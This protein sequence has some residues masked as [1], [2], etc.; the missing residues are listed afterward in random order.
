M[1]EQGISIIV[2][3]D[4]HGKV[5]N[6]RRFSVPVTSSE[7]DS[8]ALAMSQKGATDIADTLRAGIDEEISERQSVNNDLQG[9]KND[10]EAHNDI[11]ND[12]NSLNE[13]MGGHTAAINTLQDGIDHLQEQ[14]EEIIGGSSV[15]SLS[16][17][18]AIVYAGE[19]VSVTLTATSS[20][21]ASSIV[22]TGNGLEENLGSGTRQTY[23]HNLTFQNAGSVTYKA[24]FSVS[25]KTK[26]ATRNV[27]AVFPIYYGAGADYNAATIKASARTSPAGTYTIAVG[28]KGHKVFF[29]VP[30]NMTIKKATLSGFDFPL[31]ETSVTKDGL[32]YRCYSSDGLL[33]DTLEIIIT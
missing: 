18:P 28:T 5:V 30:T 10:P 21:A 19:S 3:H 31:T 8:T 11:R 6:E 4:R 2:H 32:T 33:A 12:I 26:E 1:D 15:V 7:G 22:L 20:P 29:L 13:T 27:T 14:I 9:H 17:T 23:T 16:A 25:G 24:T